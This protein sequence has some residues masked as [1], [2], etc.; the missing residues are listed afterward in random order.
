MF[1]EKQIARICI[2]FLILSG[3]CSAEKTPRKQPW[4][5]SWSDEFNGPNG[6]S[7]DP[8]KWEFETGGKGWGNDE[9]E[10]YTARP[11]NA[12]VEDG[13]LVIRALQE[14]YTGPDGVT[15]HF[16]SARL[17]TQ[18]KFSQ[19]YGRFEAR[20][21]NSFRPGHVDRLLDAGR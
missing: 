8:A 20:H 2:L 13:N 6:S 14:E 19:A 5:L 17:K 1:K 18:G 15:R 12:E 11:Q 3:V 9:L 4:V 7:V 21:Q 16:T 10:Y